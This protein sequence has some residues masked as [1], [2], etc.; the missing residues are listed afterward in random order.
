MDNKSSKII[1]IFC[2]S[3]LAVIVFTSILFLA[4]DLKGV[5]PITYFKEFS[6]KYP[7]V[8]HLHLWAEVV[9][10]V[11]VILRVISIKLKK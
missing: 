2:K 3:S 4:T 6:L 1:K 7:L 5:T 11:F 8:V 9:L 10:I